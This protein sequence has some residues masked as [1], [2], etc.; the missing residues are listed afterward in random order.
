MR[1]EPQGA[2]KVLIA[3]ADANLRLTLARALTG[4]G[5]AVRATGPAVTLLKWLGDPD[6]ALVVLDTERTEEPA[7][8]VLR[9]IRAARP[10]LP[11]IVTGGQA[12]L[13]AAVHAVAAGAFDHL[14]KPYR[15]EDLVAIATRA[16]AAP[17]PLEV[18]RTQA[19]TRRDDHLPMIGRSSLMQ[20][21]YR[22]A[23]RLVSS[24]LT[25]LLVGESGTGKAL[26]ARA[27]HDMGPRQARAFVPLR[28]AAMDPGQVE[29]RLFGG[30]AD[31]PGGLAEAD[32]GT[33]FLDAIGDLPH[34]AQARLLR[35]IDGL[36]PA[37]NPATGRP[38]KVR[39]V[40]AANQDLRGMVREGRFREDLYFRL[41]VAPLR[42]PALR[43][44]PEDI[45]D[46]A[47]AVLSR[48]QRE[49]M[50]A[51]HLDPWAE[52]RLAAHD[53]P[54]NVRE[55]ENV[56]RRICVIYPDEVIT[57]S[58]VDREL[59]DP[60]PAPATVDASGSLGQAVAQ[61]LSTYFGDAKAERP[62]ALYE[63]I[64]KAVE[65]PLLQATLQVT[66]GNKIR[67]AEI[68]GINRNT[69]KKKMEDLGL[70]TRRGQWPKLS[71][72]PNPLDRRRIAA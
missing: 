36:E 52:Q 67:A 46:L 13:T 12:S 40:A 57:A 51:K 38:S 61:A 11:V 14:T 72:E 21:L 63:H 16:M 68:L 24:D 34:E 37:I 7:F 69:L 35:L 23:A 48:A 47:R 45:P 26:I 8:Q 59:A 56:L 49:G 28:L 64:I 33:L 19:R 50:P 54:G 3:D 53:W 60:W 1:P 62:A 15:V 43:E 2:A 71:V 55:L 70:E 31:A 22:T 66:Q 4:L 9:K 6:V 27:L 65:L 20:D 39:I 41:H 58:I 17:R 25:V 5:C 10:G 30:G 32:G 29:A 44:R 18:A 42:V